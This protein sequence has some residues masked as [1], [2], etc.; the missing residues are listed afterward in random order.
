VAMKHW[1]GEDDL[2]VV[3]VPGTVV[4]TVSVRDPSVEGATFP[5]TLIA[6]LSPLL[7]RLVPKAIATIDITPCSPQPATPLSIPKNQHRI[8]CDRE[9]TN[10]SS[11]SSRRVLRPR[12]AGISTYDCRGRLNDK[13][14]SCVQAKAHLVHAKFLCAEEGLVC[15]AGFKRM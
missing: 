2:G 7:H 11:E 10:H 15:V 6:Y 14:R 5:T 3:F 13:S 8:F 4:R 1:D 9:E 12:G